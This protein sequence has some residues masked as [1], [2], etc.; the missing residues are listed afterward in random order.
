MRFLL[1][2]KSFLWL[3]LG[4]V[5]SAIGDWISFIIIP[6]FLYNLTNDPVSIGILMVCRFLPG[7]L[8]SPFVG[9]FAKKYPV[10]KIM[11]IA[12]LVRGIGF[13]FLFVVKTSFE[14]YALT[15]LLYFGTSFFN[16]CKF[17]LIAKLVSENELAKGNSYIS[18]A[19]QIMIFIGPAIGGIILSALGMKAGIV[20]N[21]LSFFISMF[22]L[23]QIKQSSTK[24][25]NKS[26]S[27]ESKSQSGKWL[28]IAALKKIA[29]R[30][31]LAYIVVGDS[32]AS[33]GFGALN[34]LFPIWAKDVFHSGEASYG[35]I[36]SFLGCGLLLGTIIAPMLQR[37]IA[38]YTL[39]GIATTIAAVFTLLFGCS[40]ILFSAI[41]FIFFV[42]LGNGIQENAAT[43]MIQSETLQQGDTTE[44]F[45][46]SQALISVCIM[47]SMMGVTVLISQ[48][49]VQQTTQ[50]ISMMPLAIGIFILSSSFINSINSDRKDTYIKK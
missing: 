45:S 32:I 8:V 14:I 17:S 16:P 42:G 46:V 21:S 15:L 26:D 31:K 12:D 22:C 30:R 47:I 25:S 36:V 23:F 37:K 41:A 43:T 48:D 27:K 13:L 11:I 9:Y 49:G 4:Q 39:Y 20:L 10:L 38:S 19:N 1:N 44:I 7:L 40:D 35:Y 50:L 34:V 33:M 2:H 6:V 3:F 5:I 24:D 29:K 28:N 18:G